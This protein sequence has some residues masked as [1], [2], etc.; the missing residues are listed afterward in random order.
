MDFELPKDF[1]ELL[2]SLN[3]NGVKY[4]LVGGYAVGFHG[5]SRSTNDIDIFV[6]ADL[7]NAK[8]LVAALTEFGFSGSELSTEIFTKKDSLVVMGVE[9]MAIDILNYLKGIDFET[10]YS[11]RHVM[12]SEN[13]EISL[14]SFSDLITNKKQ[15]GRYKDLSDVEYLEKIRGND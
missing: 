4:L 10:A 8:K 1:K 12:K 11:N 14:I 13:I 3:A 9:P 15:V 7:D 5:Y 2:E 6:S